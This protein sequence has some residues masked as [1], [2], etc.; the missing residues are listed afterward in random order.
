MQ[1]FLRYIH[2]AG[3]GHSKTKPQAEL[4]ED[5]KEE[6]ALPQQHLILPGYSLERKKGTLAIKKFFNF[7]NRTR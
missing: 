5:R 6:L 3:G 7:F 1:K 4:K 2:R